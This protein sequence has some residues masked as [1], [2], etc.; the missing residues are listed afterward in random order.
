MWLELISS[1]KGCEL[2]GIPDTGRMGRLYG[3]ENQK[4]KGSRKHNSCQAAET[5]IFNYSEEGVGVESPL[6]S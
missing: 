5:R 3:R 2:A 6:G 4:V 1:M